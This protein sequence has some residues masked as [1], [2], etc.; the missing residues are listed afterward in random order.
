MVGNHHGKYTMYMETLIYGILI[1]KIWMGTL[2][3][4]KY[5]INIS[6]VRIWITYIYIWIMMSV[7]MMTFPTEWKNNSH[8]PNHQP[9]NVP[10]R[11]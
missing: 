2:I 7:G 4:G 11:S 1:W 3:Y 10:N 8:V 5:T 9:E 6:S